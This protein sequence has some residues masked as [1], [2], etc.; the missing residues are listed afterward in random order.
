VIVF[1]KQDRAGDVVDRMSVDSRKTF[2]VLTPSRDLK[3]TEGRFRPWLEHM[4]SAGWEGVIGY[5]PSEQQFLN[6][7]EQKDLVM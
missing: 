5:P 2:F 4:R 7:L 3:G 6:A 1:D